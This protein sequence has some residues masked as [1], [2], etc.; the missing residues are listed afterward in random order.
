MLN[1]QITHLRRLPY[2]EIVPGDLIP[3]V[4][5]SSLL[6]ETGETDYVTVLN[7]ANY[8]LQNGFLDLTG[9]YQ[10]L[11]TANG[12]SFDESTSVIDDNYRCYGTMPALGNAYSLF[13]KGYISSDF[14]QD[15]VPR[16]IFGIG[17]STTPVGGTN[18]SY[19]G[20][21][22]SDL[23]VSVPGMSPSLTYPSFFASSARAFYVG[24]TKDTTGLVTLYINGIAYATGSGTAFPVDTSVV[25]MGNGRVSAQNIKSV[26]YEAH[27]FNEALTPVQVSDLFY[28][29]VDVIDDNLISSYNS[30]TLNAGPTQWLD[31]V[32][33]NHLS[34]PVTGALATNPSKRFILSFFTTASG[35]LGSDPI[36]GRNVLP[37]RYVL[38]S[39]V[40]ESPGK[41]LLSIGSNSAPSFPGDNGTGSYWDNR[42]S[43]VSASY[44]VN[45]LKLLPL[46]IGHADKT[47]WVQFS[48][49][50]AAC[51]ITF[52]GYIRDNYDINIPVPTP[53]PTPTP[54]PTPTLTTTSTP[55]GTS[56]VTPTPTATPTSTS[57]N[58]PTLTPTT[59]STPTLTPTGTPGVTPT[60]TATPTLTPTATQ[61]PCYD[62]TL[63][64]G[65]NDGSGKYWIS[66]T[67]TLCGG[68]P[69][70]INNYTAG[71]WN[72]AGHCLQSD[73][74]MASGSTFINTHVS[75]S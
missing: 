36:N 75:C 1:K 40:L 48:S 71:P 34:I 23:F 55:T 64:S 3:I 60:L 11:Q 42:V 66:A 2:G 67:Y 21:V 54:A 19:I 50:I 57:T 28:R 49:S 30:T 72:S 27:V 9:S 14:T 69:G 15:Y 6:S 53:T 35:Y 17:Q 65:P 45:P 16:I 13:V 24:L 46:G 41:P 10:G 32:G 12:L 58:T 4:D 26:I 29:G 37:D 74:T 8:L 68:S 70:S 31:D 38:T 44:G 52:D 61:P 33:P 63:Y 47:I 20:V 51:A 18:A 22:N 59:T 7:L 62:Y 73:P 25:V 5:T 56:G 43:F 39:C